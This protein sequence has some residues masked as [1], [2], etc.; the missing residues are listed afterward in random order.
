MSADGVFIS[1]RRSDAGMAAGRLADS[2]GRELGA[3]RVFRDIED[4]Q[5]GADFVT[6]LDRALDSCSTMLVLIGPSWLGAGVSGNAGQ[7]RLDRPDDWVRQEIARALAGSVRVIPVLLE[8]TPMP[9]ADELPEPIRALV[10]RQALALSDAHWTR[11]VQTLAAAI[12]GARPVPT[13]VPQRPAKPPPSPTPTAPAVA[14]VA[15]STAGFVQSVG[16]GVR[17]GF[18]WLRRA[19]L[20]LGALI[21]LLLFFT[22]RACSADT[23]ELTGNFTGDDGSRWVFTP[24][25]AGGSEGY[26]AVGQAPDGRRTVCKAEPSMFASVD[27]EC[28][29][30]QGGRVVEEF[31][32]STLDVATSPLTISGRC[33]PA[34][35]AA[36]TL[37]RPFTLRR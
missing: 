28:R 22:I 32:C 35:A 30:E 36:G 27:L 7:R 16:S 34:G 8:G 12:E 31:V 20:M 33:R 3:D 24:V 1:Y 4:I 2:L 23:P 9:A 6:T 5:A 21:A 13:A 17:T 11:D 26:Q 18:V 37:E 10:R 15:A 29:V 14:A 25:A 19:L